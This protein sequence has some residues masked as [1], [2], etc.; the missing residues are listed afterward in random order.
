MTPMPPASVCSLGVDAES[1]QP[2][3]MNPISALNIRQ[4]IAEGFREFG[5]GHFQ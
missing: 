1:L 5:L 2:F 3:A 4:E